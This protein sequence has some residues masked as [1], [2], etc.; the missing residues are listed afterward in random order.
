MARAK[1]EPGDNYVDVCHEAAVGKEAIAAC[2]TRDEGRSLDIAFQEEVSNHPKLLRSRVV[3]VSVGG[4]GRL[5]LSGM[6][7]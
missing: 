5:D 6:G 3:V 7:Y 4:K 1:L 2:C